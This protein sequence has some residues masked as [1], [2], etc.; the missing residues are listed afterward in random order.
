MGTYKLTSE[1]TG[2]TKTYQEIITADDVTDEILSDC[3]DIE[4]GFYGNESR[5]DWEDFF[6]RRLDGYPLK[7]GNY[8]CLGNEY[9]TPAMRKI[10]RHINKVR[11]E[12]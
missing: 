4:Q 9:D 2:I 3:E 12:S 6:D 5:I 1:K 8:I 11:R 7:N 10:K